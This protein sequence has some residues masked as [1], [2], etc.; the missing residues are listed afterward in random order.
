MS[1]I[2]NIE[3]ALRNAETRKKQAEETQKQAEKDIKDAEKSLQNL[4]KAKKLVEEA[5][6]KLDEAEKLCPTEMESKPEE[7][8]NNKGFIKGIAFGV[9]C[10]LVVGA[11]TYVLVRESKTGNIKGTSKAQTVA[12]DEDVFTSEEFDKLLEVA[13]E[14]MDERDIEISKSDIQDYIMYANASELANDNQELIKAIVGEQN[15]DEIQQDANKFVGAAVMENYEIWYEKGSTENFV[16]AS[17]YIYDEEEKAKLVEIEKRVDEIAIAHKNGEYDKVE[18]LTRQLL[19]DMTNPNVE[20]STL[21]ASTGYAKQ[22]ALEPVRGLFGM[23]AD[24]MT[25]ILSEDTLDLIKY[26]VPSAEDDKP[27]I[28]E[29]DKYTENNL[30]TGYL[31]DIKALIEKCM[32]NNETLSNYTS[33]SSYTRKRTM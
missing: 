7:K 30:H 4:K 25:S 13:V 12:F 29:D 15:A 11:L 1:K 20:I 8:S 19:L 14:D 2:S 31:R 21:D 24:G 16:N 23:S 6:V 10:S 9:A 27:E 17:D 5:N 33:D 22:I 32:G 28:T 3:E 26:H 18:E